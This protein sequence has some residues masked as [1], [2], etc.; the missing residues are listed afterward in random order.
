MSIH[1][2]E[3]LVKVLLVGD[4]TVGKTS[5]TSQFTEGHCAENAIPTVGLDFQTKIMKVGS[6]TIKLLIFD[7]AGQERFQSIT[8]T[9]YRNIMGII[10]V[11]DVTKPETFKSIGSYINE[12]K[13]RVQHKIPMILIGNKIDL[14]R[15]IPKAEAERFAKLNGMIY[16]ET[17]AKRG[18]NVNEIFN[19]LASMTMEKKDTHKKIKFDES[20]LIPK[21]K[22]SD[23][24]D[25]EC[26]NFFS[27][28]L[29][30]INFFQ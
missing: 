7:S 30:K 29:E 11:Y 16:Y 25:R 17:S 24:K 27:W 9:Y 18:L 2:Y 22:T 23:E 20:F 3:K 4:S 28:I 6:K 5:L 14:P 26:S 10:F 19:K 21:K 15:K 13:K 8:T 1:G 12:A